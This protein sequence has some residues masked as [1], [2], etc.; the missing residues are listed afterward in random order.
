M[1]AFGSGRIF[2]LKEVRQRR[3]SSESDALEE[4][5]QGKNT[6]KGYCWMGLKKWFYIWYNYN[7]NMSRVVL[8]SAI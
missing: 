2:H 6:C 1:A 4:R 5:R 3:E 8:R 7:R